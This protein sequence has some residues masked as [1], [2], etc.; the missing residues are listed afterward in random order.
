MEKYH[1]I[2]SLPGTSE[3]E[4]FMDFPSTIYPKESPRFILGNDPVSTD[5]K[6]CYVL[7]KG[8]K[9]VGRFAIYDNQE[10]KYNGKSCAAIGSF[11]CI[12]D[13]SVAQKLID[14][15]TDLALQMG[16]TFLI[17]PME[18]STWNNYRFSDINDVANFFMEP[19]H[20]EYYPDLFRKCGFEILAKYFSNL[21]QELPALKDKVQAFEKKYTPTGFHLRTLNMTDLEQDLGRIADFSNDAF[22]DN[23]LFTPIKREEFVKKYSAYTSYM[24]PHLILLVEDSDNQLQALIFTV[25][26]HMD[27]EGKTL[28]VKTLARKKNS[29]FKGIGTYL[30]SKVYEIAR[31]AGYNKVIHALMIED[32]NSV[33]VSKNFTGSTYKT[34]TLF[35]KKITA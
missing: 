14:F 10:L 25:P 22:S 27:P 35:C 8:E 24:D 34:Y 9:A 32:N 4:E 33:S 15:A 6:G 29:P 7:K 16:K 23:F 5:L 13:I 12:N 18:G 28:I 3:F 11:E 31:N 30:G 2:F 26:D 19:F 17:G 1:F 21:D 20:H